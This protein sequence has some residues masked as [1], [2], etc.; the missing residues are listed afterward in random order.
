MRHDQRARDR[1]RRHDQHVGA[2]AAALRLQRQALVHAEAVLLVDDGEGEVAED[3]VRLEQRVRADD[4]VDVAAGEALEQF[5]ARAAL[6]A[7]GEQPDAQPGLVGERRDRFQVL[8][9]QHFRR[10]HQRRLARRPPP[11]WPWRAAPR[12]SCRSRRRPAAAAACGAVRPCRLDLAHRLALGVGQREGQGVGKLGAHASI[13]LHDAARARLEVLPHQGERQLAGKQLV[14]GETLPWRAA[15]RDV[16]GVRRLV[17]ALQRSAEVRPAARLHPGRLLPLRHLAQALQRL[18]RRLLH[19]LARQAGGERIDRLQH[20][21]VAARL[22]RHDVVGMRHLQL[23][24]VALDAPR[25]VALLADGKLPL[26]ELA[27]G[28]EEHE[29]ELSRLV[30]DPHLVGRAVVAARRRVVLEDAHLERGDR[31]RHGLGDGRLGAPVDDAV[32]QVPQQIEHARLGDAGRQVDAFAHQQDQPRT[33]A[34]QRLQRGE[35]G[36][37]LDGPHG[38]LRPRQ[39]NGARRGKASRHVMGTPCHPPFAR[40]ETGAISTSRPPRVAACPHGV[41]PGARV[42]QESGSSYARRPGDAPPARGLSRVPPGHQGDGHHSRPLR[43]GA[44]ESSWR[45]RSSAPSSG[46][47]RC[48]TRC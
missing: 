8:A 33:D 41:K 20:R 21:Q 45:M 18:P 3:D 16:A 39:I 36:R 27:L 2:G 19:D 47:W 35:E 31:A 24:A 15:G 44:P 40:S 17:Q 7:P 32:G 29:V 48:P 34:G 12:P 9:R 6:L 43:R 26:D 4:D 14:V 38:R 22:R 25:H 5:L 28:V 46:F 42:I 1:R 10:R 37:Q 23:V 30:L 13:A 11:R